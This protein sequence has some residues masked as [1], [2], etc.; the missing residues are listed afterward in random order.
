MT[1]REKIISLYA[2]AHESAEWPDTL[3]GLYDKEHEHEHE[4]EIRIKEAFYNLVRNEA[5]EEAAKVCETDGIGVKYQGD[6]YAIAIRQLK[7]TK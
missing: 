3:Q 4:H 5:L 7:E 1:E 6:V 2:V